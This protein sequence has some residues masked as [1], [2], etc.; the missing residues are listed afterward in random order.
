MIATNN[1]EDWITPLIEHL[2]HE[3][4][5]DDT[6]HKIEV[7]R[8]SS[9]FILYK[10]ILYRRS[11][12]G[13]YQR[14]LSGEEVLEAMRE[15]H[16]GVCGAHQSGSKLH[17]RIK[18]MSYY[19]PTMV[20]DCLEYAKKSE[21]WELH[22]NFI[23]Q[24]PEPL[25]PTVASWL[26]DAWGLHVLGPITPKSSAGYIYILAATDYFSKWAEAVPLKEVKKKTVVDF[27]HVNIIF[28]YGVP[29]YTITDNG[30]PFYNKSMDKLWA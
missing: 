11:F 1:E 5:P 14:C 17:F 28:R 15:T 20:K 4:L 26:F 30:R 19:W 27:I 9:R 13:T 18:R 2:K 21:S 10:D 12:E 7:R 29:R 23:H 25:H 24:P 3:K 22:A 6:R 8:R 16:S